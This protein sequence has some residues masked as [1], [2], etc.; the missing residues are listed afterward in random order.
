[1]STTLDAAMQQEAMKVNMMSHRASFLN[2]MSGAQGGAQS[3][4]RQI[5]G[6]Q[7]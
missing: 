6:N 7:S 5:F 3:I 2:M 1:V 4:I